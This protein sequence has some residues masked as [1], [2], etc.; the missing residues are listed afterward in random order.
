MYLPLDGLRG[1]VKKRSRKVMVV[2]FEDLF[3]FNL[4]HFTAGLRKRNTAGSGTSIHNGVCI[5]VPVGYPHFRIKC[6]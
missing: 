4:P 2:L 3:N 1:E 5:G 6:H